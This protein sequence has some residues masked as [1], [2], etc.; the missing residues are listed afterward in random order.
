MTSTFAA[1]SW[2]R[3]PASPLP[4]SRRSRHEPAEYNK[5]N[6]AGT[7]FAFARGEPVAGKA[8]ESEA[9][10][11]EAEIERRAKEMAEKRILF[12]PKILH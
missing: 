5:L 8:A 6:L 4:D 1:K 9:K 12:T 11:S 10:M 2:Q 7:D 3:A